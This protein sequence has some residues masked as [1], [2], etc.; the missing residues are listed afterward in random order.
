MISSKA[1]HLY[2]RFEA[3]ARGNSE[4]AYY[5]FITAILKSRNSV[6][7]NILMIKWSVR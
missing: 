5:H 7:T 3:D 2:P 6:S 1:E 4:M